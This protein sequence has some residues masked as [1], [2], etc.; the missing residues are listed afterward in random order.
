MEKYR[1]ADT[2]YKSTT[3]SAPKRSLGKINSIIIHTTGYGVGLRRLKTRYNGDL[4]AIGDAYAQRMAKIL[5]FK[6]HFLIDHTGKVYQ[7]LA[8]KEIAWHT[9]SGKRSRL[10][11]EEPFGWWTERWSG[12]AKPTD[13]PSWV[14]NSPNKVSIGIDLLAHGNGSLTDGYTEEQYESLT[15]LINTLCED[16]NIE[17]ERKFIVGHEDVDPIARGNKKAGWDPGHFDW[18]KLMAGL[19]KPEPV[20]VPVEVDESNLEEFK[21]DAP[22]SIDNKPIPFPKTAPGTFFKLLNRFLSLLK[23]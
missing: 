7:F 12:L 16:L 19:R 18:A 13:L 8:P 4:A 11:R 15:K 17:R 5:K 22:P 9:G 14:E 23:G 10:K 1:A 20:E 2:L 6:G 21:V 3:D